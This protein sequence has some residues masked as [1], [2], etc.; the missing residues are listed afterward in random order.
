MLKKIALALVLLTIMA[1]TPGFARAD[2]PSQWC[3][4]SVPVNSGQHLFVML[5]P[6]PGF[7]YSESSGCRKEA[8]RAKYSASGLY[9]P[10]DTENPLWTVDFWMYNQSFYVSPDGRYL[11]HFGRS[12]WDLHQGATSQAL[13]FYDRASLL[14]SY[15]TEDIVREVRALPR[16]VSNYSWL[17]E[18]Q[19]DFSNNT[20]YVKTQLNQEFTYDI[21]TGERIAKIYGEPPPLDSSSDLAKEQSQA[22]RQPLP[23][24]IEN[25]IGGLIYI[26]IVALVGFWWLLNPSVPGSPKKRS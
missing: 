19:A 5:S 3:D 14:R 25:N 22:A 9:L 11:I 23:E 24:E 26:T 16:S 17:A 13:A 20:I 10:D 1:V 21:T 7:P 15:T 12:G 8:L 4:Y 2:S 6:K 18:K